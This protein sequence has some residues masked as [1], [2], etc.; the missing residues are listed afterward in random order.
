MI[1]L[2]FGELNTNTSRNI[3]HIF[4]YIESISF[5]LF[6]KKSVVPHSVIVLIQSSKT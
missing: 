1:M 4:L 6:L 2:S 5:F 3:L